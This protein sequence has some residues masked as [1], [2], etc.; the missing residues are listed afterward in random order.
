MALSFTE[1]AILNV[2]VAFSTKR[3][4]DIP[5]VSVSEKPQL[6]V[7]DQ[8]L[9]PFMQVGEVGESSSFHSAYRIF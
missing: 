1:T 3:S 5:R 6:P 8:N 7:Y 2:V 9:F 4:E